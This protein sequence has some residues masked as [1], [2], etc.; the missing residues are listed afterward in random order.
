[1]AEAVMLDLGAQIGRQHAHD[2]IYDA[3]Q[4]AFALSPSSW[5]PTRA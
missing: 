3:A 4:S 5:R 2:V 1:M